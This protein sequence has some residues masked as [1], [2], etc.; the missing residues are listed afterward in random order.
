MMNTN[1]LVPILSMRIRW[2]TVLIEIDRG[3]KLK[4]VSINSF[5]RLLGRNS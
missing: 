5:N 1:T 3:I 2:N 4:P